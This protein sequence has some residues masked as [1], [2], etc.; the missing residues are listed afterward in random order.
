LPP[1]KQTCLGRDHK[2]TPHEALQ[3]HQQQQHQQQQQGGV[4]ATN[5]D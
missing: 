1:L 3:Q 4:K 2:K 5:D